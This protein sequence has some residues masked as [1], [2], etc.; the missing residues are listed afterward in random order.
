MEFF[1]IILFVVIFFNFVN[2]STYG[3][4]REKIKVITDS[5]ALINSTNEQS[6]NTAAIGKIKGVVGN[7]DVFLNQFK[8]YPEYKKMVDLIGEMKVFI[9]TLGGEQYAMDKTQSEN[10]KAPHELNIV[11]VG[12]LEYSIKEK[13][14]ALGKATD[15]FSKQIST[16][17]AA[18]IICLLLL[19]F[20]NIFQGRF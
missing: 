16:S 15:I 8:K 12:K 11:Q 19:V 13:A 14:V 18:I 9:S 4:Y 1:N 20:I 3:R 7:P 2:M 5:A 6:V 17:W 10:N